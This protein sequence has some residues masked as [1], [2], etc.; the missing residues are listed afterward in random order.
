MEVPFEEDLVCYPYKCTTME[1]C[2]QYLKEL[3]MLEVMYNID[4]DK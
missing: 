2:V 3:A 1:K 4:L